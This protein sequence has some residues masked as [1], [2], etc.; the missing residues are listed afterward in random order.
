MKTKIITL[1]L[2]T[3]ITCLGVQAKTNARTELRQAIKNLSGRTRIISFGESNDKVLDCSNFQRNSGIIIFQYNDGLLARRFG[4]YSKGTAYL[5][6]N[7]NDIVA[8]FNKN[9]TGIGFEQ[10]AGQLLTLNIKR[11]D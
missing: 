8:K 2:T 11:A 6:L 5:T 7:G 1:I 10:N 9:G 3:L 4:F